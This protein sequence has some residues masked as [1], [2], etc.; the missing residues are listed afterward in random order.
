MPL[1]YSKKS[2]KFTLK[3]IYNSFYKYLGR[4]NEAHDTP[5]T[6]EIAAR[7]TKSNVKNSGC[8]NDRNKNQYVTTKPSF[9]SPDAEI[10]DLPKAT[11]RISETPDEVNKNKHCHSNSTR[12]SNAGCISYKATYT[13]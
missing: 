10:F 5:T 8:K 7:M 9:F 3:I 12:T 6:K 11:E 1:L 4:L 2:Q 13:N